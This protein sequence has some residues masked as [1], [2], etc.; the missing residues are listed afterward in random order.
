VVN[1]SL[2]VLGQKED[3]AR[4]DIQMNEVLMPYGK[5]TELVLPDGTKVWLNAGSRIAFPSRFE[6]NSRTV[7]LE[8]EACFLV[9]NDARK[10]FIV[11]TGELDIKVLGTH[12]N[13]SAYPSEE[14]IET[15]LLEG[16]VVIN[17]P[18][19]M[20][21]DKIEIELHPSQKASFNRANRNVDITNEE[22]TEKYIAWTYGWLNYS[23]E[24]LQS[25]LKKVER[26]YN[27]EIELPP[28]Y[29]TDDIISGK[30]D[31]KNSLEEVMLALSDASDFDYR[32]FENKVIIT[33]KTEP[34]KRR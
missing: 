33:K 13:V 2:I 20:G 1:D 21:R 3:V 34:L 19:K 17:K 9:V 12:F 14:I 7:F 8:G 32:I 27:A 31:L 29:P 24:S 6:K 5:K 18:K 15:V 23:R 28:N 4:Q 26:F 25:V 10:K 16:S 30:L 11:K 22:D